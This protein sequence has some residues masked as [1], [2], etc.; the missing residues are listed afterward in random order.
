M[1]GGGE[2]EFSWKLTECNFFAKFVSCLLPSAKF[3]LPLCRD[4]AV[5]RGSTI[6]H[7]R[8]LYTAPGKAPGKAPG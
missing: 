5:M 6:I 8:F 7:L 3:F 2:P 4:A 1:N